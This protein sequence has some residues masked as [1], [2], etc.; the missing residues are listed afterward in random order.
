MTKMWNTTMTMNTHSINTSRAGRTNT[1]PLLN[2]QARSRRQPWRTWITVLGFL[3]VGCATQ[4]NESAEQSAARVEDGALVGLLRDLELPAVDV[5]DRD[6]PALYGQ[7]RTWSSLDDAT[8]Q[9]ILEAGEGYVSRYRSEWGPLGLAQKHREM[10]ST[11]MTLLASENGSAHAVLWKAG[12]YEFARRVWGISFARAVQA[13]D[14]ALRVDAQGQRAPC[15]GRTD[16]GLVH[17]NPTGLAGV[18]MRMYLAALA[19]WQ[20]NGPNY[21]DLPSRDW[22]GRPL[23]FPPLPDGPSIHAQKQYAA[24][25]ERDLLLLQQQGRFEQVGISSDAVRRAK[26]MLRQLK[27]GS[28]GWMTGSDELLTPYG[29]SIFAE[30]LLSYYANGTLDLVEYVAHLNAFFYL[31]NLSNVN[32]QDGL[33]DIKNLSNGSLIATF[34]YPDEN[35]RSIGGGAGAHLF[36]PHEARAVV[37]D[38]KNHQGQAELELVA[39]IHLHMGRW[40]EQRLRDALA[41]AP[42]WQRTEARINADWDAFFADN[43]FDESLTRGVFTSRVEAMLDR[44]LVTMRDRVVAA[45]S[46]VDPNLAGEVQNAIAREE[47]PMHALDTAKQVLGDKS[48][49]FEEAIYG[50]KYVGGNVPGRGNPDDK[51]TVE[52]LWGAFKAY[53]AETYTTPV[54][55]R[56]GSLHTFAEVLNGVHFIVDLN[57]ASSRGG[58]EGDTPVIVIGLATAAPLSI[59]MVA[60]TL[61]HEAFHALDDAM[62]KRAVG[63]YQEGYPQASERF[64]VD[65]FVQ[66]LGTQASYA[67]EPWMMFASQLPFYQVAKDLYNLGFFMVT[68]RATLHL[69]SNDVADPLAFVEQMAAKWSMSDAWKKRAV[70]RSNEGMS[71]LRYATGE[72]D[73]GGNAGGV[74]QAILMLQRRYPDRLVDP[75]ALLQCGAVEILTDGPT[76]D[77]SDCLPSARP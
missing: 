40:F 13:S 51:A 8:R 3:V 37:R 29:A 23:R 50:L 72:L 12:L 75:Y 46:A 5:F 4:P 54:S 33:Y 24:D 70:I 59:R 77:L 20:V 19:S 71:Y 27:H 14:A 32:G 55:L 49:E 56:D 63:V 21:F 44:K 28:V 42:R 61:A 41:T 35:Q 38:R 26:T 66:W 34:G 1:A 45:A 53:V 9:S 65:H 68:Y 17:A 57:T 73:S 15:G 6:Q 39:T 16:G 67:S 62:G 36:A 10:F 47:I 48:T 58:G 7:W 60:E 52:S 25:V 31:N 43:N 76:A 2:D 74:E 18:I 64:V 11:P 30:D 69:N 22:D